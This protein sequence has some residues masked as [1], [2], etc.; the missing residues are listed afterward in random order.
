MESIGTIAEFEDFIS[1]NDMVVGYFSHDKCSVC[2]VLLPKIK[3]LIHQDFPKAKL[4]YCDI[5]KEPALAAQNRV[6]TAPVVL[7]FVQGREYVRYSRNIG[8]NQLAQSI[9]RPY[10]MLFEEELS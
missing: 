10:K 4:V 9:A 6:F 3:A 2:K 8:L 5:E 7:V 1:S